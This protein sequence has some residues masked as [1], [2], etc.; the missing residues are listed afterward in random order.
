MNRF[1]QL[2]YSKNDHYDA[3]VKQKRAFVPFFMLGYPDPET[4]LSMIKNAIDHNIDAL[5]LGI[6]FSDPIAD[7]PTNQRAME[8]AIKNGCDFECCISLLS[9]IRDYAPALPIGLLVYYNLLFYQQ[10]KGYQQLADAGVD[11]IV[12]P[13]LPLEETNSHLQKLKDNRIGAVQM[14]APNTPEKRAKTLFDHSSAFTYVLS[15]YGTTGA[16]NELNPNTLE[17]VKFLRSLTDQPMI[18]GF[19]ISKPEHALAVWQAG[20]D[21]VIVG[22]YFT[23]MIENH[24]NHIEKAKQLVGDFIDRINELKEAF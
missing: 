10:D 4:S 13:D 6:P 7:G 15:G 20:A 2:F 14:I 9:R 8:K 12:S 19:G 22:S 5:E 17:R 11:A 16:K 3:T 23:H 18:V 24:L 21:G 1:H